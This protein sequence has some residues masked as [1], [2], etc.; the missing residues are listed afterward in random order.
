MKRPLLL[1]LVSLCV[2]GISRAEKPSPID[3]AALAP[4]K[5]MSATLGAAKAFAYKSK[6]I[7]EV[8]AET[9]QFVTL[10]STGDVALV[11]PDKLRARLG[12]DAPSFDF[13]YDGST[14]SAFAPGTNVYSTT[15]APAT[16]DAMLS[17]LQEETGIRFAS[18]PLLFNDP[19]SIL[20]RDLISAVVVGPSAVDGAACVHLAFRSEGVNW[21]I[22][23][24]SNARALPRR[25]AVTFTDRP[26]FPRTL[27]DFSGWNLHPWFLGKGAFVFEKPAGSKEI[28]FVSVLHSA[29]R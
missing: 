24:E 18:A 14:V 19:Y 2:F 7:L 20:T 9:G 4:L 26:N 11:R 17:G 12:G 22:W 5:Q 25:L 15:K 16:I 8:P 27:V 3:P 6:S 13:Y 29:D 10:F 28:P 21:E 23:L 1:S